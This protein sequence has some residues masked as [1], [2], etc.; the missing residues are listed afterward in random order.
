M[1]I[2]SAIRKTWNSGRLGKIGIILIL[3]SPI[4]LPVFAWGLFDGYRMIDNFSRVSKVMQQKKQAF[5]E[6]VIYYDPI[7]SLDLEEERKKIIMESIEHL[8]DSVFTYYD[9]SPN[10]P[11]GFK[12]VEVG[13][14]YQTD[15]SLTDYEI[16]V[17]VDFRLD[18]QCA[19]AGYF[20]IMRFH[21][22]LD[23]SWD[24]I[25]EGNLDWLIYAPM[26]RVPDEA[27]EED[28]KSLSLS[29]S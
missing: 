8:K 11:E 17:R 20:Y 15:T 21:V 28:E 9:V 7:A 3:F 24:L 18:C 26:D 27:I 5:E 6:Y 4:F 29:T 2:R 12:P 13:F 10:I 22:R 25:A 23:G 16:F 14:Y 19:S 1:L